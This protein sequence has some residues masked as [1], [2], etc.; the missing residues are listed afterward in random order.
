MPRAGGR[1]YSVHACNK[2]DRQRAERGNA[3]L[4]LCLGQ[5]DYLEGKEH[6]RDKG[7]LSF[8]HTGL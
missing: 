8:P 4:G 3:W 5:I 2:D 1:R 6:R 7:G